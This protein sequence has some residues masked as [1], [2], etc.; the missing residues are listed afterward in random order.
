MQTFLVP[1]PHTVGTEKKLRR[2]RSVLLS[3]PVRRGGHRAGGVWE[4][5][6]NARPLARGAGLFTPGPHLPESPAPAGR[7][8]ARWVEGS[9]GSWAGTRQPKEP[10]VLPAAPLG[11]GRTWRGAREPAPPPR[12]LLTW[13]WPRARSAAVTPASP[14][15]LS[16]GATGE[17][18]PRAPD[19]QK[20]WPD[21]PPRG[22]W[23]FA[24]K[25]GN[26][27]CSSVQP[28]AGTNYIPGA[29][30]SRARPR[31]GTARSARSGSASRA[32][33]PLGSSSLHHRRELGA[34][35]SVSGPPCFSLR[36]R[37]RRDWRRRPSK[38]PVLVS[39]L[40]RRERPEPPRDRHSLLWHA[41]TPE[42]AGTV[43]APRS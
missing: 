20:S 29:A 34:F 14:T 36:P 1:T 15:P 25:S 38:V 18:L 5:N 19:P 35:S 4:Q 23:P 2:W 22:K 27:G 33:E 7:G 8:T 6:H 13:S 41:R 10:G 43:V 42:P 9:A 37:Q 11:D 12:A 40:Q 30:P 24:L 31:P 28:G 39:T 16:A 26:P 21:R 32:P 17:P 3:V